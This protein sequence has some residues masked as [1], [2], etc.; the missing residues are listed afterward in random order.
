MSS[1]RISTDSDVSGVAKHQEQ[2]PCSEKGRQRQNLTW[3]FYFTVTIICYFRRSFQ[4][5]LMTTPSSPTEIKGI[6]YLLCIQL[7]G[8]GNCLCTA[9][10]L[11]KNNQWI[12]DIL[13]HKKKPH[14]KLLKPHH[15][16]CI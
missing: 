9:T 7:F 3:T 13:L 12:D 15:S 14:V 8:A 6:L 2:K 10:K 5:S 4:T 11:I 1:H 16:G